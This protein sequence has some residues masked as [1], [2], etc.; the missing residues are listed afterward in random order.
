MIDHYA[1]QKALRVKLLTLSVATTGSVQISATATGYERATGSFLTD[2]F[3]SGME[4][5]GTGFGETANN[6]K[7]TLSSVT[8]LTMTCPNTSV[9]AVGARTLDV[10]L[11]ATRAWENINV[12]PAR[13]ST[14]IE[15]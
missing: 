2:G 11:P 10:G 3:L 8:A 9:E 15:E 1:A 12:E 5:G 6:A 13:G 4:V 7:K 14:W